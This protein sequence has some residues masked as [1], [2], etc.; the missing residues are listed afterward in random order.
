MPVFCGTPYI[1]YRLNFSWRCV[2]LPLLISKFSSL[3]AQIGSWLS[4]MMLVLKYNTNSQ[5]GCSKIFLILRVRCQLS[6]EWRTN[7]TALATLCS[8]VSLLCCWCL[9]L[10]HKL[11]LIHMNSAERNALHPLV[12]LYVCACL[13]V[14]VF[15][16]VVS[17]ETATRTSGLRSCRA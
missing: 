13:F 3:S 7:K 12:L 5:A 4:F 16:P 8:C 15:C 2:V 14:Y 17:S 1:A 9:S 6:H 11:Q 10:L